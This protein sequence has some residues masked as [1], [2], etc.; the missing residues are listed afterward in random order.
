MIRG[1]QFNKI[2]MFH[3]T[4]PEQSWD[5]FDELVSNAEKLGGRFGPSFFRLFNWP[6]VMPVRHNGQKNHGH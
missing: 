2:E 5:S 4:K 3:Y 1:H 6:L